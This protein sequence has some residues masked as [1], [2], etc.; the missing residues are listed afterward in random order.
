[1][2]QITVTTVDGLE[3]SDCLAICYRLT[4]SGSEWQREVRGVLEGS[5]SSC[6]PVAL[7]HDTG[8]LVGWACSHEWRDM[9]T[10]EQF[11]DVRHR[12][13]GIGTALAAAL[14]GAGVIDPTQNVAVFG[15]P[16]Q[17]LAGRLGMRPIRYER[18]GSDWVVS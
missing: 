1:M 12:G 13:R 4:K 10:L 15:E 6:T 9:Q 17:R 5:V 16:T 18:S 11:T 3:P 8:S 2:N 14:M 7:W